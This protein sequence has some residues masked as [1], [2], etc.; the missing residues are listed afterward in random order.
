[1]KL[2][3]QIKLTT[4]FLQNKSNDKGAQKH[5]FYEKCGS[6]MYDVIHRIEK[7]PLSISVLMAVK[8]RGC[9][10]TS[11]LIHCFLHNF[12]T[13][14]TLTNHHDC[15]LLL[16]GVASHND[17]IHI[18]QIE[19]LHCFFFSKLKQTFS[20]LVNVILLWSPLVLKKKAQGVK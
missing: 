17:N 15:V 10:H 19:E 14:T 5:S 2:F 11:S 18:Q 1:M 13:T 20:I 16:T 3:S 8:R 9:V 4:V 12:A 7:E 6:S